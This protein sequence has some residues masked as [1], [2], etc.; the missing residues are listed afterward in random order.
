MMKLLLLNIARKLLESPLI[1]LIKKSKGNKSKHK[2]DFDRELL[3]TS[4]KC[5]LVGSIHYLN[6][7]LA[8]YF[9]L[10]MHI[11]AMTFTLY[12]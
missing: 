5:N 4:N 1:D 12:C 6:T 7:I 3:V 11:F 10:N 8:I 9:M 2:V